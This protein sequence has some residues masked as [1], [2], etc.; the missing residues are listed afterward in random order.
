MNIKVGDFGLAALIESPSLMD[1]MPK[2]QSPLM[3][4]E[5]ERVG[6]LN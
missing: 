6:T 3:G 5:S 1:P 4:R 2:C